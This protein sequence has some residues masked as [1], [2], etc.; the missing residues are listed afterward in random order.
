MNTQNELSPILET[1]ISLAHDWLLGFVYTVKTYRA[2]IGLPPPHPQYPLP[3]EFPFGDLTEVF[4]WVQIFDNETQVDRSFCLR[5]KHVEG[6]AECWEP[7]QW[8]IYGETFTL[9]TLELDRRVYVDQFVFS[10]DPLFVLEG[11]ADA[12]KRRTKLTVSSRI[13][14]QE[15]SPV[16]DEN[17]WYELFE[18]RT[19]SDE[20]V[21]E[22]GRRRTHCPSFY[23]ERVWGPHVSPRV[24]GNLGWA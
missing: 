19:A 9:G 8:V 20:L 11:M 14:M 1:L 2:T 7:L 4:H 23:S 16:Q 15:V 24:P 10:V 17:I 18:V 5:I 6:D 22:L 13:L 21:K 12:V 3:V